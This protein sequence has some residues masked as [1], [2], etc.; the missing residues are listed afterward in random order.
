MTM[1]VQNDVY[2]QMSKIM[3]KMVSLNIG[4]P[5]ISEKRKR[6]TYNK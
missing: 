1:N 2:L 3:S 5:T 6:Y 4:I